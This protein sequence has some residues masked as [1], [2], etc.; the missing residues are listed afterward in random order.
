MSA[1]TELLV[2]I[3]ESLG[4]YSAANGL[5]DHLRGLDIKCEDYINQSVYNVVFLCLIIINSLVVINYYYGLFNRV[6]FTNFLSWLINVLVGS[7]FLFFIGYLYANND[8][9]TGNYCQE[10]SIT[11]SDCIGF[12]LTASIF[13]I[14]WSLILSMVIKWKSSNNKKVPF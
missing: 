5:G 2:T 3:F 13:S 8:F 1:I 11:H 12:G 14:L 7:L 6:N 9:S 4:L 10:L